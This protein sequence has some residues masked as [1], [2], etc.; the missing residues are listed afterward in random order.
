MEPEHR[1]QACHRNGWTVLDLWLQTCFAA[2]ADVSLYPTNQALQLGVY[3][4]E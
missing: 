1:D 3:V 2:E 4:G